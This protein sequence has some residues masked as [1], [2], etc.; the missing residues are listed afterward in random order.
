[1]IVDPRTVETLD[2]FGP[3]IAFLTAPEDG[4]PCVMRGTV[5]AG[6]VVPLHS[7]ADPETFIG[8][9]GSIEGLAGDAGW[10]RFGP[11]DVFHVPGGARHA[12]RNRASEPAVMVIVSTA[13]IGRFFREVSGPPTP[14]AIQHFLDVSERYG[15]W[16]ATPEESAA[17][18][19]T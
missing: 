6:G 14:E 12:F 19:A 1:M 13:T 17:A 15:Y 4:V 5:P 8:L 18:G 16:N 11:G 10:T 2:L 7:H 3:T 9:S